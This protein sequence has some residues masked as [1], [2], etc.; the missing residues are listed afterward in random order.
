MIDSKVY[1]RAHDFNYLEGR[2]VEIITNYVDYDDGVPLLEEASELLT[3]LLK[4]VRQEQDIE[5]QLPLWH[6]EYIDER[7]DLNAD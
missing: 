2:I 1:I 6:S 3:Q 5:N 4:D 7:M